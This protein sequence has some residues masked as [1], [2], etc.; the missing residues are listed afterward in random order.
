MNTNQRAGFVKL[1]RDIQEEDPGR[2]GRLLIAR[3]I[4]ESYQELRLIVTEDCYLE[5][6]LAGEASVISRPL[7]AFVHTKWVC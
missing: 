7:Q 5:H 2:W 1:Q 3:T 6:V 4:A